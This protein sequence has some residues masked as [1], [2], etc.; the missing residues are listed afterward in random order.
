MLDFTLHILSRNAFTD[1]EKE[2]CLS[3]IDVILQLHKLTATLL[4]NEQPGLGK[5]ER[6]EAADELENKAQSCECNF[7]R[8]GLLNILDGV[9]CEI[10]AQILQQAILSDC[11]SGEKLLARL[12]TME[13]LLALGR[14]ENPVLINRRL[15]S[16]LGTKYMVD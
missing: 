16:I 7:M 12:I 14:M 15:R 13:G 2:N 11:L 9:D 4:M 6:K 10:Q 5:A 1:E 3:V 8:I